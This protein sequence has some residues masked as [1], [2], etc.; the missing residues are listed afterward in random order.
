MAV[1]L[2]ATG[3]SLRETKEIH[4]MFGVERSHQVI[5]QCVHRVA[6]IVGDPPTTQPSRVAIDETAIKIN[7]E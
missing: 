7:G 1:R 2:H 4:R 3:C 5:S 6:D